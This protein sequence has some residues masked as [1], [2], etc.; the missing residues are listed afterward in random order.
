MKE[1]SGKESE[2]HQIRLGATSFWFLVLGTGVKLIIRSETRVTRSSI[3]LTVPVPSG[4][5]RG[6]RWG[7]EVWSH[8]LGSCPMGTSGLQRSFA[9]QTLGR[10]FY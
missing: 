7:Y 4:L 3:Q 2:R 6:A 8:A 1:V 9:Q 10:Q 5:K